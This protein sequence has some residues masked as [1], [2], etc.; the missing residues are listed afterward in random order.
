M[1]FS[2]I[3]GS[4]LVLLLDIWV[5]VACIYWVVVMSLPVLLGRFLFIILQVSLFLLLVV[6]HVFVANDIIVPIFDC[7]YF[8]SLWRLLY[9]WWPL[10]GRKEVML[11]ESQIGY[12]VIGRLALSKCFC[13]DI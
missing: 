3:L 11:M 4:L 5:E 2:L 13:G 1:S 6:L 10:F 12:Y 7:I 9:F 8:I